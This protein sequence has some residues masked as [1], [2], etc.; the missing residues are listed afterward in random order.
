MTERHLLPVAQGG[1][2]ARV[3]TL[4]SV[5]VLCTLPVQ[6]WCALTG[7]VSVRDS[8]LSPMFLLVVALLCP[9]GFLPTLGELSVP[10]RL[11]VWLLSLSVALLSYLI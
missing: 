11:V 8:H 7:D 1:P 6:A 10:R 2:R 5:A 3:G 4:C 9:L